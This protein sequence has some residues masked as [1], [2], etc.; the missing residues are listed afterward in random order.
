MDMASKLFTFTFTHDTG[1]ECACIASIGYPRI[2]RFMHRINS[3]SNLPRRENPREGA[4]SHA[5]CESV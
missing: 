4:L 5:L 2:H 3:S 1:Q